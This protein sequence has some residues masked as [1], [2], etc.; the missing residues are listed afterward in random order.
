[1]QGKIFDMLFC[2]HEKTSNFIYLKYSNL[3]NMATNTLEILQ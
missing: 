3:E 1:M 2:P